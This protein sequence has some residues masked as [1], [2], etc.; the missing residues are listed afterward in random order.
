MARAR[1]SPWLF[2]I[3]ARAGAGDIHFS[4]PVF[5]GLLAQRRPA[6][7]RRRV[8]LWERCF[9]HALTWKTSRSAQHTRVPIVLKGILHS[10]DAALSADAGVDALIVSNHGRTA[11]G[12]RDRSMDALPGVVRESEWAVPVLFDSGIRHGAIFQGLG[13]FSRH[14]AVLLGRLYLWALRW[15]ASREC[16]TFC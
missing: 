10:N 14:D 11:S 12:W 3:Y 15:P 6:E 2:A 7:S 13:T 9:E 16:G 1:P 4:D 8:Q 5:R